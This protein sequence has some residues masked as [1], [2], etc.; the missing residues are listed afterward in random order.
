[1]HTLICTY[2]HT[3]TYLYTYRPVS[4]HIYIHAHT[5][6]C[7][8]TYTHA[9]THT[10]SHLNAI[11]SSSFQQ[12]CQS[13]VPLSSFLC[14]F[15]L[16]RHSQVS[17]LWWYWRENK[18]CWFRNTTACIKTSVCKP[19]AQA[20]FRGTWLHVLNLSKG[21]LPCAGCRWALWVLLERVKTQMIREWERSSEKQTCARNIDGM[22][23]DKSP[24]LEVNYVIKADGQLN[25]CHSP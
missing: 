2:I 19:F 11:S 23:E 22:A 7:V 10:S 4:S 16:E 21:N 3:N 8:Y 14:E 1:M 18:I 25:I 15:A 20:I 6:T 24:V 17:W 13:T 12:S 9:C 5:D